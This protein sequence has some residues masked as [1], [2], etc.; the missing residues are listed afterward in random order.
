MIISADEL[1]RMSER[2]EATSRDGLVGS[3]PRPD[4]VVGTSE[5][6]KSA[7]VVP[8]G[9]NQVNEAVNLVNA[10]LPQELR[11]FAERLDEAQANRLL[12]TLLAALAIPV[13]TDD[14]RHVRIGKMLKSIL[15]NDVAKKRPESTES[16]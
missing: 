14:E 3:R 4:V 6:P 1:N 8:F 2:T 12:D 11:Q 16:V 13:L 9:H 5:Q 15:S 10:M 7:G